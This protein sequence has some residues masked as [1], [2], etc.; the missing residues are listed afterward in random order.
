MCMRPY[1]LRRLSKA[2]ALTGFSLVVPLLAGRGGAAQSGKDP[3][4]TAFDAPRGAVVMGR[5]IAGTDWSPRLATPSAEGQ[6]EVLVRK[7]ATPFKAPGCGSR[8]LVVRMPASVSTEPD[9]PVQTE[10]ARKRRMF[11]R[12]LDAYQ[13]GAS[14][15]FDVFAGPY[16]KRTPDGEVLLTG[17]NIFFKEPDSGIH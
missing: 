12:M 4:E 15:H 13:H 8:Y 14:I 2:F 6:F 5:D 17:C 1:C 10:V 11:D 7:S 9:P 3:T 16:G